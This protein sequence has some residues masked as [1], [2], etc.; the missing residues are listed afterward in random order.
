M[1]YFLLLEILRGGSGF[2]IFCPIL[3]SLS[4]AAQRASIS[5]SLATKEALEGQI[6][7]IINNLTKHISFRYI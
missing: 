4:L 5:P 1:K 2:F 7:R 3:L 6:I